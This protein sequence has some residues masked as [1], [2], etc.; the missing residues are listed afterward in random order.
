MPTITPYHLSF[1]SGLH[2]GS[3]GL[4]LDEARATIPAD[5]LF[6]ALVSAWVQTGRDAD[7]LVRPFVGEEPDPPFLLSSA[8][9]FAGSVRFYPAPMDLGARFVTDEAHS[10]RKSIKRI[11]WISEA[12]L[13]SYLAG[14]TLDAALFPES[15]YTEPTGQQGVALQ[16]GALWLTRQEA[17]SLP[18]AMRKGIRQEGELRLHALRQHNVWQVERVPRVTVN[19][20]SDASNIYHVGRTTFAQGCGL[21]FGVQW[22]QPG[23]NVDKMTYEQTFALLMAHLADSGLGGERS[24]GYGAFT[25]T[26]AEDVIWPDVQKDAAAL[27]LSRYHPRQDELPGVLQGAYRLESVAGWLG[28]PAGADQRRKRLHLLAEGSLITWP[29]TPAGDVTDVRPTYE[30]PAGNVPHPVWRYGLALA[31][32]LKEVTHA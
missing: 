17:D 11:A 5:T 9:P 12:L 29:D 25:L 10:R 14:E 18:D 16:G 32:R 22:L 6:S 31:V 13:S 1:R 8:F 28:S 3:R 30:N 21:W 7:A 24:Y 23:Q 15:P 27:L 26:V 20:V 4:D 2:L 19:R